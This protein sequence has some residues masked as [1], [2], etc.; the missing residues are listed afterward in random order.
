MGP[1]LRKPQELARDDRGR[2][3]FA[4]HLNSIE[5]TGS[6]L[7]SLTFLSFSVSIRLGRANISRSSAAEHLSFPWFPDREDISAC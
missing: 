3:T 5:L 4:W 2:P 7:L 6:E 1:A